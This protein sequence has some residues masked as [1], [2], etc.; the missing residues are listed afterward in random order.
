MHSLVAKDV[1]LQFL[2]G[3]CNI[4]AIARHWELIC[5]HPCDCEP[6]T[7]HIKCST[8][9]TLTLKLN[10]CHLNLLPIIPLDIGNIT[11]ALLL[12]GNDIKCVQLC[13]RFKRLRNK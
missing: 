1:L 7:D 2:V 4:D 8:N 13:P 10:N 12:N 5:P 6:S 9:G 3:S 11:E